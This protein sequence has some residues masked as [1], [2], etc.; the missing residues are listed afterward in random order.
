MLCVMNMV[1]MMIIGVNIGTHNKFKH[2]VHLQISC[3]LKKKY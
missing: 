2:N 3:F 1:T